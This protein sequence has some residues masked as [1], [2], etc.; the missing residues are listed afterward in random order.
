MAMR[1]GFIS[2]EEAIFLN[3]DLPSNQVAIDLS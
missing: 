2:R 1:M 3:H